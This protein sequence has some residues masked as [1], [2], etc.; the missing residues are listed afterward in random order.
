MKNSKKKRQVEMCGT[1]RTMC[2]GICR[3][4]HR[5]Y[6]RETVKITEDYKGRKMKKPMY[7]SVPRLCPALYA[8]DVD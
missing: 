2:S 7:K 8:V 3:K 6:D 4:E 1:D 5:I